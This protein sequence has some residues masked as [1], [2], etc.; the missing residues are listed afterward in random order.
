MVRCIDVYIGVVIYATGY[1]R[2]GQLGRLYGQLGRAFIDSFEK[3]TTIGRILKIVTT[4]IGMTYS[5][6]QA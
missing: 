5:D 4:N 6:L 3:F 2:C 1:E